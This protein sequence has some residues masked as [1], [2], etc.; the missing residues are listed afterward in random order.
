MGTKG[1]CFGNISALLQN[2]KP[3]GARVIKRKRAILPIAAAAIVLLSFLT[4]FTLN[5]K[6]ALTEEE[7]EARKQAFIQEMKE[8]IENMTPEDWEREKLTKGEK[9]AV[10][11]R[12][13]VYVIDGERGYIQRVDN[14]TVIV[15]TVP[16]TIVK[17]EN[18]ISS[19]ITSSPTAEKV[20]SSPN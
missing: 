4:A 19:P 9:L 3:K 2:Q 14:T 15:T 11:E 1:L 16:D 17:D 6:P 5:K 8:M 12:I 10:G 18:A 7:M 13:C 20:P